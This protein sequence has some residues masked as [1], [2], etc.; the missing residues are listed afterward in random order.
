AFTKALGKALGRPTFMPSVPGFVIKLVKGEFGAVLLKGQR[1]FPK[2]L[3]EAGF[4][5]RFPQISDALQ[6]LLY[7]SFAS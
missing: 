2:R 3:S 1:V 6:D 5:F 7:Q 4:R